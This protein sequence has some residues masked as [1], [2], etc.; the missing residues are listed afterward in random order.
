MLLAAIITIIVLILIIVLL[1]CKL[2]DFYTVFSNVYSLLTIIRMDV[3][4]H[5]DAKIEQVLQLINH[6][7]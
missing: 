4:P 1:I 7:K 6:F 2:V 3:D 5:T